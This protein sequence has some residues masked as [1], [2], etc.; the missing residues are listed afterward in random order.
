[1]FHK[2]LLF[3]E[4]SYQPSLVKCFLR[5]DCF[6]DNHSN[7]EQVATRERSEFKLSWLSSDG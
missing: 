5:F 4:L 1:M 3:C 6:N 2:V 7:E